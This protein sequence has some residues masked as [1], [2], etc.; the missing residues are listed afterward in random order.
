MFF[1]NAN[2]RIEI[3]LLGSQFSMTF[4]LLY[5]LWPI[6]LKILSVMVI[7][8]AMEIVKDPLSLT[9]KDTFPDRHVDILD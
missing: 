6:G 1:Q 7:L 8:C 9:R 2:I 3:Y 4:K 5:S